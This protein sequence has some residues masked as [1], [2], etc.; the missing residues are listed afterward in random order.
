[1]AT[2]S[3]LPATLNLVATVGNDFTLSLTVTESGS[4]WVA[5][6]ATLATDIIDSSGTV[7]ATDF[8]TAASTGTVSLSLTDAN[9]TTLGVGVYS[10]R[11]SVTKSS[12]TRDWIAGTLSIV[13]AGQG[14][15]STSS[16]SLSISNSAVSL[17]LTS[18]VAPL[19]G[20]ISVADADGYYTGTTVEAVLAEQVGKFEPM[21]IVRTIQLYPAPTVMSSPPTITLSA[22]FAATSISGATSRALGPS[23]A[24]A[25]FVRHYGGGTPSFTTAAG[26]SNTLGASETWLTDPP[27]ATGVR[28]QQQ[29][30]FMTDAL[31]FELRL[32]CLTSSAMRYR[33]WVDNQPT[34]AD[35]SAGTGAGNNY[36]NLKV[37]LA[38]AAPRLIR[39]ETIMATVHSVW[40]HPTY[41]FWKPQD[42]LGPRIA[43]LGDSFTEGSQSGWHHSWAWEM[44][45][46]LGWRDVYNS[47][48]GGTGYL[49][50]GSGGRST[51]RGRVANDII[52]HAPEWVFVQGGLND[53]ASGSAAITAEA[54]LLFAQIKTGLPNCKLVVLSPPASSN[55][56][57]TLQTVRDAV[58][59]AASGVADLT[60]DMIDTTTPWVFGTG[61]S[62]ATTGNG[63]ADIYVNT[64]GTHYTRAGYAYMG[65]R[66]AQA[67]LDYLF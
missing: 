7:V 1:M 12:L 14:G 44:C 6:G 27:G 11:L 2:Y 59:A 21:N 50:A 31:E 39:V 19:A 5:T 30:E 57:S 32:C 48:L 45:H 61:K 9:T 51:F 43:I 56:I 17:S 13:E 34:A 66:V 55:T 67:V 54:A 60:I 49:N 64:D 47:G 8:T 40:A 18:L 52:A 53:T 29:F 3:A 4:P 33:I 41:S 46:R 25:S 65:H 16:A 28:G 36:Y 20:N 24:L 35:L 58:F 63:N 22:A 10:Y 37:V 62:G 15:T 23:G 42:R 38:S 26:L